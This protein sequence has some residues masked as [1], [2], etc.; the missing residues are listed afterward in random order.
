MQ[1]RGFVSIVGAGP[2]DP[3]LL[4]LRAAERLRSSDV[5]VYDRLVHPGV[6]A[7]VRPGS[8]LRYVG[9]QSGTKA[10]AQEEINDLLIEL[11][12]RGRTVVRLKGG[13][14]FMF[15]RGGEEASALAAAGI[16]FEIVPGVSSA[17]AVPAFA[18]IPVTDRRYSSSVTFITGHEVSAGR[19]DWASVARNGADTLVIMMGVRNLEAIAQTLIANGR[20]ASTPSAVVEWGT[21]A[22]QRVVDAPLAEIATEVRRAGLASP[23]V[24][25]VGDVVALRDELAWFGP[26]SITEEA[27]AEP[28]RAREASG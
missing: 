11:A 27:D 24:V 5:V 19:V 13:D 7:K 14:P 8:D 1:R 17:L 9:K 25:I 6:L 4:T 23:A 3:D 28:A 16:E 26:D 21:Y 10:L 15:G 22:R 2:G 12:N 20:S 18:G